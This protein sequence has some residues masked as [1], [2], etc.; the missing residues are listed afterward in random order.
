MK[1]TSSGES[2]LIV[3]KSDD[4]INGKG[5]SLTYTAV[6]VDDEETLTVSHAM[7]SKHASIN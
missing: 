7:E 4:S 3:F 1:I 5:F 2:M 6:D